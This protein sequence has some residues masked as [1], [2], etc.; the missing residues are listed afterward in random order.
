MSADEQAR[1]IYDQFRNQYFKI[2]DVGWVVDIVYS[3]LMDVK[4]NG[5]LTDRAITFKTGDGS[6]G[7]E[8]PR[9]HLAAFAKCLQVM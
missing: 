9:V 6:I 3:W 5:T 1:E 8:N 2:K 4:Y 7:H